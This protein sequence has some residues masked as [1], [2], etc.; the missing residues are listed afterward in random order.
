MKKRGR[1]GQ[2]VIEFMVLFGTLIFF[3]IAFMGVIQS[4]IEDKNAEKEGLVLQNVA[5]DM[6]DEVNLAAKSS[7]GYYREFKIPSNILGRDYTI[8]F[9]DNFVHVTLNGVGYSYK[10]FNVTGTPT[11]GSNTIRKENGVVYLN[12]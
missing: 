11:K 12:S 10:I 2:G 5:L 9:I 3:F 7:D 4:N 8:S 6:R 1:S